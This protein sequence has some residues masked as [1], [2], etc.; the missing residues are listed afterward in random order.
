[1][2]KYIRGFHDIRSIKTLLKA[3]VS[4][5]SAPFFHFFQEWRDWVVF[6]K[7]YRDDLVHHRTLR[8]SVKV[9]T[10][11][12][13][14]T[15]HSDI[16]PFYVPDRPPDKRMPDTRGSRLLEAHHP[17]GTCERRI[18][19]GICRSDGKSAIV[20]ADLTFLPADGYKPIKDLSRDQVN[21][22]EGFAQGALVEMSRLNFCLQAL[23]HVNH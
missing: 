14:D 16:K 3:T 17:T 21:Q 15:L 5:P 19:E 8:G 22:L 6:V 13:A 7:S 9:S 4:D 23:P 2:G 11:G 10:R 20:R 1:M 18:T 12:S